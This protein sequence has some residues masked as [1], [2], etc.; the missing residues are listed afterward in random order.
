MRAVI[1]N[2]TSPGA[3]TQA[4]IAVPSHWM[5][6]QTGKSQHWLPPLRDGGAPSGMLSPTLASFPILPGPV[7]E[8]EL[9]LK[10]RLDPAGMRVIHVTTLVLVRGYDSQPYGPSTHATAIP[11]RTRR[12][13]GPEDS[14][15]VEYDRIYS[16]NVVDLRRSGFP[17]HFPQDLWREIFPRRGRAGAFVA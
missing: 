4:P 10:G 1:R 8:V 6:A 16:G 11:L 14:S 2:F 13:L 9:G 3:R 7:A 17:G 15:E 12:Y 5:R